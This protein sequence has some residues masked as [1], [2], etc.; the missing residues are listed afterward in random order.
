S[1]LLPRISAKELTVR[2]DY[3]LAALQP[4]ISAD[5]QSELA[6]EAPSFREQLRTSTAQLPDS[7]EHQLRL[8]IRPFTTTFIGPPPRPRT[9]EVNDARTE[10]MRWRNMLSRHNGTLND[11]ETLNMPG[12]KRA[13]HTMVGMLLQLQEMEDAIVSR[14]VAVTRG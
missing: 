7:W 5:S 2:V 6:G 11:A 12:G 14:Q 3:V 13:E 8:D 4:G 9:L 1:W 10:R